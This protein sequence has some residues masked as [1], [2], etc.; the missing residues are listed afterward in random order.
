[1]QEIFESFEQAFDEFAVGKNYSIDETIK[2]KS[3]LFFKI[4][5]SQMKCNFILRKSLSN[6]I[7]E[8]FSK[9]S[10]YFLLLQ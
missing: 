5:N 1:L 6:K 3:A 10:C 2:Y 4:A 7:L 9:S 8:V